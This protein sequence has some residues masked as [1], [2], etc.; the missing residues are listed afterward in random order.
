MANPLFSKRLVQAL[1]AQKKD[2]EMSMFLS[3]LLTPKERNDLG[4]RLEILRRL[5]KGEKQRSIAES[6]GVGIA[7]VTRGARELQQS[8]GTLDDILSI[9]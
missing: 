7:T 9:K 5:Y 6:L 4:V 1:R 2:T 3:T 8:G